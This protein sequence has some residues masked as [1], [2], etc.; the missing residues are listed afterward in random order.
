MELHSATS[1]SLLFH[2]NANVA[3]PFEIFELQKASFLSIYVV[4]EWYFCV[5]LGTK[6]QKIQKKRNAWRKPQNANLA[7]KQVVR[8]CWN[9]FRPI[10]HIFT[11]WISTIQWIT[12][13]MSA[14]ENLR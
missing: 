2:F 6:V 4:K 7:E 1:A 11:D 10:F 3:I 8:N 5:L 14:R 9:N 12:I 13:E